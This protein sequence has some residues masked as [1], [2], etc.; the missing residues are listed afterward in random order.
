MFTLVND[1]AR[2]REF[3]PFCIASELLEGSEQ[4]VVGRI[5]FARLGLSHALVTRN[6]LSYPERIELSFV[7]GPFERFKGLWEFQA[8][9]EAACKVQ[10]SVDFQI[11]ASYLQFAAGS[12][13][14]QAAGTAVEAFSKRAV[15]L[16][17]KR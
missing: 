10:F 9:G 11:Q 6:R 1:V 8:L 15:Q 2:Y 5:A 16:Y 4:E 13:L 12:A 3:L 14:N 7:E 17:G